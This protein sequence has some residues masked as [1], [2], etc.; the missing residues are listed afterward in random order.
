[1]ITRLV[2]II[3]YYV[4]LVA[5]F[6]LGVTQHYETATWY[7]VAALILM[8]FAQF[9]GANFYSRKEDDSHRSG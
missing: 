6:A 9:Q 8:K 5:F 4:A 2:I 1:M 7:G 3:A